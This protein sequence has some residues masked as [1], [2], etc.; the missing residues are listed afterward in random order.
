MAFA[1][2]LLAGSGFA[3]GQQLE[4]RAYS[5]APVGANFIVASYTYQTGD[6]VFDPSLPFTDVSANINGGALAYVRTFD[7]FGRSA[8]TGVVLPYAWGHVQGKVFEEA[9]RVYRSGLADTPMRLS[10]NLLGGPAVT[11]A[12]FATRKPETVL[13][14]TAV[15]VA[16]TGQYN[17]SKLINIGANRW[18]FKTELGASHP[19]GNWFF[20]VYGGV[21]FF[22]TNHDFFGGQTKT[23]KPIGALQT[24]VSYN[25]MPR[26]WVAA[27]FTYYWGGRSTINGVL[28]SDLL[29]NS[30][31]GLTASI[32]FTRRSSLKFAWS[33]G[34]TTSIGADFSTYSV[35]YQF[36]WFDRP[37][38][39]KTL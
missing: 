12:E 24:H 3:I 15:V 25:V 5:P 11:P 17:G 4:P 20:D 16:P 14:F 30:R 26:L 37:R 32:P 27:D 22:T 2:F 34:A 39:P 36:L 10:V 23:Q 18:A 8:S 31:V 33:R 21:W 9:R 19:V 38:G 35:G 1:A 13:G 29:K 6:V 28:N 7:L